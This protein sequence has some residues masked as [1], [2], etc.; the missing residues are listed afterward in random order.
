VVKGKGKAAVKRIRAHLSYLC[1]SGTSLTGERSLF[2]NQ[3]GYLTR[4][5]LSRRA[6][7][8]ANDPH[9][10]RFIIS[11]ERASDLDL[12][13][14]VKSVLKTMEGDLKTKLEWYA[15]CHYNTDNPHAHVVVRGVDE[16]GKPLLMTRDYLGHGIRQVA[17]SEASLRLGK[18]GLSEVERGFAKLLKEERFT[19]LDAE[20][21][22]TQEASADKVIKLE[23][24]WG[25]VS[26][27]ER[28]A[29]DNQIR[30]LVFLEAKGLAKELSAGTWQVDEGLET[31][32]KDLAQRR[33]VEVLIAPL[34]ANRE[35]QKQELI[36]HQE[37]EPFTIKV[38]GTVIA[39]EALDELSDKQFI[40]LSGSDGRTH[41]VPLGKF[42]E[43]SGFEA[44]VGQVV[45][46]SPPKATATRA[47]EVISQYVGRG[48]GVFSME[49]FKTHVGQLAVT[50]KWK[51]PSLV[52]IDEYFAR[53]LTRLETL[54]DASVVSRVSEGV[55][56]IPSDVVTRA[57]EYEEETRKKHFVKVEVLSHSPLKEQIT[58]VGATWIDL[59]FGASAKL[60]E[61]RGTFRLD[62][63]RVLK[64][65]KEVLQERGLN[66]KSGVFER[67]LALEE[68][69]LQRRLAPRYGTYEQVSNEQQTTGKVV[70]YELLG[71][72]YRMVVSTSGGFTTRKV[73]QGEGQLPFQSE[74]ALQKVSY[75]SNGIQRDFVKVRVTGSATG[76][77]QSRRRGR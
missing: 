58:R 30:R 3:Q 49:A 74:V 14:Y 45:E 9:H 38:K 26:E 52:T 11:P 16:H 65:R 37:S 64:K 28:K 19:S 21:K 68:A 35:E 46:I 66:L 29:R 1:R 44:K 42:S 57:K 70:G 51:I 55:W 77:D 61:Y 54:T 34:L 15:T 36:V 63:E 60:E 22:R 75:R 76:R 18:R 12:E 59:H 50:G 6:T 31:V 8:W 62:M 67:L 10:F 40:L 71:D 47:E 53:Y 33:K 32:L 41:F 72:G 48:G 73:G 43:P 5:E 4:E 17:E 13:S 2:F 24:L 7:E 25:K 20:L 27:W 56:S 23:P 69:D 39:K